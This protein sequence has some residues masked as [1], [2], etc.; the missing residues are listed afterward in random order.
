MFSGCH[1]TEHR[2]WM[3]GSTETIERIE[4]S[5]TSEDCSNRCA[6]WVG[7]QNEICVFWQHETLHGTCFLKRGKTCDQP[8]VQTL[9]YNEWNIGQC[10]PP[11]DS[12]CDKGKRFGENWGE[13]VP[14]N[15][16]I[17]PVHKNLFLEFPK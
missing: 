9:D 7:P 5:G 8:Q 14:K 17:R 12:T 15:M 3:I 4:D 13:R 10:D 1:T 16:I 11:S 6:D 2:R